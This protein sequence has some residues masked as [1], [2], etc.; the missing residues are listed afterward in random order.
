MSSGRRGRAT[1]RGG[2]G[3]STTHRGGSFRGNF[4]GAKS[5]KDGETSNTTFSSRGQRGADR[6]FR[7]ASFRGGPNARGGDRGGKTSSRGQSGHMNSLRSSSAGISNTT[8]HKQ[9]DYAAR[10]KHL[11][12]NRDNEKK[13]FIN[14]G[15]MNPDGPMRLSDAVKIYGICQDMC[16]EFERVRRIVEADLKPPEYT[17]ESLATGDRRERKPDE[18]RMVKAYQRSAAGMDVELV[19]DIRSPATCLKTMRYM[20]ERLDNEDFE[21]LYQWI[22]DRTRAVRK[23]LRTQAVDKPEDLTMYLECFEQCARLL[24]LCAHHMSTSDSDD[25]FQ[26]QDLDQLN[27]TNMSLKERYRDNRRAG[28]I[29]PN[30]AEFQAYRLILCLN[31]G[32]ELIEHEIHSLPESLLSN[33]RLQTALQ[34]SR[35]GKAIIKKDRKLS[36]AQQNWQ[37]FWD[38]VASPAVSYLMACAAEIVFNKIRDIVLDTIWR[39]YRQGSAKQVVQIEDWTVSK[40]ILV[41]GLDSP[42][43]VYDFCTM[44]GFSFQTNSS[45]EEYLD[46]NSVPWT[47]QPLQTPNDVKPQQFSRRL[48]ESKRHN[49]MLSAVIRGMS[50]SE[51]K[52]KGLI[53]ESKGTDA[54]DSL[55]IPEATSKQEPNKNI[56]NGFSA[57]TSSTND[58]QPGLNPF[59]NA[60]Q[61]KDASAAKNPFGAPS[62][63]TASPFAPSAPTASPF[64]PPAA[65]K[66]NPFASAQATPAASKPSP[67]GTPSGSSWGKPSGAFA[68]PQTTSPFSQ[69]KTTSPATGQQ[70]TPGLF[71][72]SKNSI[73]FNSPSAASG[74]FTST[75]STPSSTTST[76]F[77]K[78]DA[79]AGK[80]P[81]AFKPLDANKENET[82]PQQLPAFSF[83]SP[84]QNTSAATDANS[85]G[86][87]SGSVFFSQPTSQSPASETKKPFSFFPDA[88]PNGKTEQNDTTPAPLAPNQEEAKAKEEAERKAKEEQARRAQEEQQRKA[89]EAEE[90]RRR[91]EQERLLQK[92]REERE[93]AQRLEKEKREKEERDRL[94]AIAL[95]NEQVRQEK[96]TAFTAL[97]N[98]IFMEETQGLLRQFIENQ[99]KHMW[100]PAKQFLA[101]EWAVKRAEEMYQQRQK[102]R[103]RAILY[104]W[105]NQVLKRKRASRARDRRRWLKEHQDELLGAQENEISVPAPPVQ[106]VEQAPAKADGFKKPAQPAMAKKIQPQPRGRGKTAVNSSKVVA[107]RPRTS[108]LTTSVYKIS[109]APIDRTETD[110]FELRAK[111]IDPSK[112]GKRS[113]DFD[114]EEQEEKREVAERKRARLSVSGTPGLRASLPPPSTDEE[115]IARFRAVRDSLSKP[116]S[117]ST[118]RPDQG[119]PPRA[120]GT[121]LDRSSRLIAEARSILTANGNGNENGQGTPLKSRHEYSRSVPDLGLGQSFGRTSFGQSTGSSAA[122]GKAAYWGRVS[123]FVPQ[124]LYGKGSDAVLDYLGQSRGSNSAGTS[125]EPSQPLDL[126]SPIPA[127]HL[128]DLSHETQVINDEAV[129]MDEDSGNEEDEMFDADEGEDVDDE[130]EGDED[131][132]GDEEAEHDEDVEDDGVEYE[133]EEDYGNPTVTYNEYDDEEG[134]EEYDEEDEEGYDEDDGFDGV[135]QNINNN[136]NAF[137]PGGTQDD[138]IELS[139]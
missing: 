133:S 46:I 56:T 27:Q 30:E 129:E 132:E 55:F 94:A 68:Q 79:P 52:V 81:F 7:G 36:V 67:F 22:W 93:R 44:Y 130:E 26:Y 110:W 109:R 16:P 21:F 78:P 135:A 103:I 62:T 9:D 1:D 89:R 35:A 6:G 124:H 73:K 61:P 47:G 102:E 113:H 53:G 2:R 107:R 32:D 139:D 104:H 123:R 136:N 40:L 63:P 54:E 19:S 13:R 122:P 39:A 18:A 74:F 117:A 96:E 25:Y 134:E 57:F 126:S 20:S 83:A 17:A 49:R 84:A 38:L 131:D 41:L 90:I 76:A 66:P 120:A 106:Q 98:S 15:R 10:L 14:E 121:T 108:N 118:A 97:T 75:A 82:K 11:K 8:P 137:Q 112:Y 43:E 95:H 86:P 72:A 115:R 65:A 138:A 70:V 37:A 51:A 101:Y 92:A 87:A 91:Q 28:I 128:F 33:R 3:A 114:A 88:T 12:D 85:S 100:K 69:E 116:F 4:N 29:S 71:D 99:I 105:Y 111:G 125:V 58:K 60:F 48:V 5:T 23:D 59:A 119:T 45:G 31:T 50:V 80:T 34:I 64:A 24:L 77:P 127:S 42:D